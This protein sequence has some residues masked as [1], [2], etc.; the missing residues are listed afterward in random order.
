MRLLYPL[1]QASPSAGTKSQYSLLYGHKSA[2]RSIS[3]NKNYSIALSGDDDGVAILWDMS[4][5]QYIRTII[6][7]ETAF[8]SVP[9]TCISDTLGDLAV[10]SYRYSGEKVVSSKLAVFTINGQPVGQV[11]TAADEPYI[12]S[13]CYSTC[14]EGLSINAI[15]TGLSNGAIKLW[16]SWDLTL[17]RQIKL[18]RVNIPIKRFVAS[19]T[20]SHRILTPPFSI[21]Y[22]F[23][24][25][26]L[27]IVLEDNLLVALENTSSPFNSQSTSNEAT[28]KNFRIL[29]LTPDH[30]ESII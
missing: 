13:L 20:L 22:S 26:L 24:N 5:L 17:L 18:H 25:D 19:V 21:S 12:T 1:S 4:K 11:E 29:D 9:H 15:A 6:E 16:S 27:Y 30:L 2:V 7:P 8:G 23:T 14:A 3:I 10:V 28:R